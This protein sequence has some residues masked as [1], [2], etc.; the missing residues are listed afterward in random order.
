MQNVSQGES[1]Q[2]FKRAEHTYSCELAGSGRVCKLADEGDRYL[3]KEPLTSGYWPLVLR[4]GRL[5][6]P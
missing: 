2:C 6:Q 1:Q 5:A 3:V 4:A